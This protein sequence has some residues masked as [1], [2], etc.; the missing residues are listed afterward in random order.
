MNPSVKWLYIKALNIHPDG[1]PPEP[2]CVHLLQVQGS[3]DKSSFSK[4]VLL[5][6]FLKSKPLSE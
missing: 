1:Q 5:G 2:G 4:E 3:L 6:A